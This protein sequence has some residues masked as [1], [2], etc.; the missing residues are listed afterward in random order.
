VYIASAPFNNDFYTYTT[1][2]TASFVT[3]G[4]LSYVT[5]DAT[6]T[7]TGN[8]LRENGKKLFPGANPG[9]FSYL[10]GVYD[11]K[12][13]L[14]GY[15]NPNAAVFAVMN[16]DKPSYLEDGQ[17]Y[18]QEDG[19]STVGPSNE[20]PSV[21]TR[22]N[23]IADGNLTIGGNG[24]F[25]GNVDLSG[26]VVLSGGSYEIDSPTFNFSSHQNSFYYYDASG[27]GTT[28]DASGVPPRGSLLTVFFTGASTTTLG[29][30]IIESDSV[31]PAA[32][33]AI[34]VNFVSN[35]TD[36][37]ELSRSGALISIP[38]LP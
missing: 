18:D 4:R 15:I 13:F 32:G 26:R 5:S 16:N 33:K 36:L 17:D 8:T 29:A 25:E 35:G 11:D 34:A 1:S 19:N 37:I 28:L 24:S 21:I 27:S 9:V 10:V 7:P 30:H 23:V 38:T 2:L 12:T 31:T 20:G 14:N 6:L 3:I 22:G